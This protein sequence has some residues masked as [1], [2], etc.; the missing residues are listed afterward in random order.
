MDKEDQVDH[1]I[2]EGKID[3]GEWKREIER[4]YAELD[5]IEKEIELNKQRGGAPGGGAA[6]L[7]D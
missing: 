1:Q 3:P 5:G 2:L 7:Y 4:V 6:N